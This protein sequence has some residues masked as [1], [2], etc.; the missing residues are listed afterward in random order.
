[1]KFRILGTEITVTFFFGAAVTLF[2]FLDRTGL[3]LPTLGAVLLHETGHLFAMWMLDCPP[4][5]I[6]LIP[7]SVQIGK[8]ITCSYQ[9]DL[10]VTLMGPGVNLLCFAVFYA[11]GKLYS[12]P[13]MIVFAL[14]HLLFGLFN[15][16]P[17][18]GLD[19]GT[20]LY[21]LLAR[22]NPQ[23]A[24]RILFFSALF[25]GAVFLFLAVFFTLRHK[26]NPSFYALSLYFLLG[27][28]VKM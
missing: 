20:V 17:V 23:K 21:V 12:S 2:L 27:N 25:L 18:K 14:I 1:M 9:T 16:L 3:A 10:L 28:L 22:K 7:S 19:G 24:E 11:N 8:K 5:Y 6:R 26:C 15:L 13:K 4:T